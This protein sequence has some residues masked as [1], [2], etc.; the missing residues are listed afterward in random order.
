MRIRIYTPYSCLNIV[1]IYSNLHGLKYLDRGAVFTQDFKSFISFSAGT[2][3]RYVILIKFL[4]I[5][6]Y[7]AQLQLRCIRFVVF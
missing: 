5:L 3:V 4:H 2:N 1:N 6:K 7:I